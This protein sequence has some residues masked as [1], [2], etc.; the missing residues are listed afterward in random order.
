MEENIPDFIELAG[1]NNPEGDSRNDCPQFDIEYE[2]IERL[3]LD[4]GGHIRG[5]EYAQAE[6]VLLRIKEISDRKYKSAYH[7][8]LETI[9]RLATCYSKQSKWAE[10]EPL[11]RQLLERET[12]TK[13]DPPPYYDLKHALAEVIWGKGMWIKQRVFA[14]KLFKKKPQL[15][16]LARNTNHII[17]PYAFWL[18]YMKPRAIRF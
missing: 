8:R 14:C 11:L 13:K 3:R 2:L 9:Y 6:N 4:A 10:A 5:A 16:K 15:N 18:R 12:L 1:D 17:D 7:W